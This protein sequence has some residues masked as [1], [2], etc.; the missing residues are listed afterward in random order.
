MRPFAA[1][2]M[3]LCVCFL[4]AGR[5]SAPG[6]RPRGPVNP[7]PVA[8]PPSPM[9]AST[10]LFEAYVFFMTLR[11][12]GAFYPD[13]GGPAFIVARRPE[14]EKWVPD[15]LRM[16]RETAANMEQKIASTPDPG[17]RVEY[18]SV[19]CDYYAIAAALG[20]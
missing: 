5:R 15:T 20:D 14:L 8:L 13:T 10:C 7:T 1:V 19:A 2:S 11:P 3:C 4:G 12:K 17:N 18:C 9:R 16:S 6:A